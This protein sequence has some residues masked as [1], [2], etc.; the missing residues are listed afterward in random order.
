MEP[1]SQKIEVV[2]TGAEVF[3]CARLDI[4]RVTGCVKG[5]VP[6]FQDD[7]ERLF[8]EWS[9]YHHVYFS[10]EAMN[11]W[12]RTQAF[13]GLLKVLEIKERLHQDFTCPELS[14]HLDK[15]QMDEGCQE[16]IQEIKQE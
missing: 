14:G 13:C 8:N 1:K 4:R 11:W 12:T 7:A 2:V 16:K 15:L 3:G 6:S 5:D 9:N 10:P